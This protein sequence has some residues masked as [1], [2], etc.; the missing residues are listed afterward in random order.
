PHRLSR[1]ASRLWNLVLVSLPPLTW[2]VL[3]NGPGTAA[4]GRRLARRSGDLAGGFAADDRRIQSVAVRPGVGVTRR[5]P[6]G[7]AIRT[8][9]GRQ[10]G[11][12]ASPGCPSPVD[13]PAGSATACVG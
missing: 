8:A 10:R 11:V 2:I 4:R 7:P 1:T 5:C 6:G 3:R 12:A 13:R 9:T